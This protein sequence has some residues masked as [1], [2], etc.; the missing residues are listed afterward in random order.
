MQLKLKARVPRLRYLVSE[1]RWQK[2]GKMKPDWKL[3]LATGQ[4]T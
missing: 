2:L 1:E 3:M 4:V